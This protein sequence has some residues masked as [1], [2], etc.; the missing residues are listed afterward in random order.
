MP[1]VLRPRKPTTAAV[2]PTVKHEKPKAEPKK[3]SPASKPLAQKQ[4]AGTPAARKTTVRKTS[5][6]TPRETPIQG[7]GR[8]NRKGKNKV[9]KEEE[10]PPRDPSGSS[11]QVVIIVVNHRC[12]N[13]GGHDGPAKGESSAEGGSDVSGYKGKLPAARGPPDTLAKSVATKGLTADD[14]PA[15]QTPANRKPAL[16][17]DIRKLA[18]AESLPAPRTLA[19]EK[20]YRVSTTTGRRSAVKKTAAEKRAEHDMSDDSSEL[21]DDSGEGSDG[22]Y[23][24]NPIR[25]KP[26]RSKQKSVRETK[27]QTSKTLADT[28][29]RKVPAQSVQRARVGKTTR[30]PTGK[31]FAGLAHTVATRSSTTREAAMG[32]GKGGDNGLFKEPI[33][34]ATRKRPATSPACHEVRK[35]PKRATGSSV[36]AVRADIPTVVISSA[37]NGF[38]DGS[39]SQV[40]GFQQFSS[41]S[42]HQ[43]LGLYLEPEAE[44][45]ESEGPLFAALHARFGI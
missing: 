37:G 43:P 28:A 45:S 8:S 38:V 23:K 17:H 9:V 32:P 35:M 12:K 3:K 30:K 7:G 25:T 19:R 24:P 40:P 29:A 44:V 5:K 33:K 41:S 31:L 39:T 20:S 18:G 6:K 14:T 10:N 42:L 1:P 13:Q 27:S 34:T 4:V 2:E 21:R 26:R 16:K 22:S 36:Q 15:F 11:F